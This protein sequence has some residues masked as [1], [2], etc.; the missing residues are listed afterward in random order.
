MEKVNSFEIAPE[1]EREMARV[2]GD[3]FS[4]REIFCSFVARNILS[5]RRK[6]DPLVLS[7]GRLKTIRV[8]ISWRTFYLI[9]LKRGRG[10]R[11]I[12]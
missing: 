3:E 10:G 6:R 4:Y 9:V 11:E 1:G 8:E 5:R 2:V 7:A 12:N